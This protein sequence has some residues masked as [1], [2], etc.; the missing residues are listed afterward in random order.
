MFGAKKVDS[1]IN[2]LKDIVKELNEV[3]KINKLESDRQAK[4]IAQAE[5]K[6]REANNEITHAIHAK[7]K[8]KELIS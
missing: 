3:A 7:H 4:L 1:V 6:L 8:I 2:K 5:V